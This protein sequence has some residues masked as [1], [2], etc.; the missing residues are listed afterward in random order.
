LNAYSVAF[1][2]ISNSDRIRL[3]E[4]VRITDSKYKMDIETDLFDR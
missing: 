1:T 2:E 4:L 3:D